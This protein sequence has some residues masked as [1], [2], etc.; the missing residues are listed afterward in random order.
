VD[1]L[2]ASDRKLG[3]HPIVVIIDECQ[4]WTE[5]AVK[6]IAEQFC[7]IIEELVRKGPAVGIQVFLATQKV[8]AKSI[9]THISNMA[10]VRLC[11]KVEDWQS[12]NQILGPGSYANGNQ[13][14]MFDFEKDK[15][16]AYLK[17]GGPARIVRT[18]AMLDKI[19]S[20]KVALR[21]R[22]LRE[23][24]GRLTGA[25]AGAEM[26]DEE[27]QVVL[28]D[29]IRRVVGNAET[30]HLG[31][32]VKGLAEL[33]PATYGTLNSRSLGAQLKKAE[34]KVDTVH[35]PE[36]TDAVGD[37]RKARGVRREWLNVSTTRLVGDEEPST[38]SDDE[39]EVI[40]Q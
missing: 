23:I 35:V 5:H 39:P 1:T 16:V 21:A 17:D 2:L 37:K 29:D 10:T 9:P 34:V 8:D 6:A 31:D 19:E 28:L 12:N 7:S 30:M 15:G 36:K 14:T 32:I 33:R 22:A 24:E 4:T 40:G 3:L 38:D 18:V 11:F 25:A 20:E 26:A 13:A 27:A